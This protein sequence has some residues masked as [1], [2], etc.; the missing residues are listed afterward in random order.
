M[1]CHLRFRSSFILKPVWRS[2]TTNSFSQSSQKERTF[3]CSS[4]VSHLSILF[5]C[6]G[7]L[8]NFIGLERTHCHSLMAML[9]AWDR[10]ISSYLTVWSL[11][12]SASLFDLYLDIDS[13]VTLSRVMSPKKERR[14]AIWTLFVS[15]VLGALWPTTSSEYLS[16]SSLR[17][18]CLARS[19]S[20][21]LSS[22]IWVWIFA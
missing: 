10:T 20:N 19:L 13:G 7:I 17:V 11:T 21:H 4:W 12:P 6:C 22:V 3:S 1:S 2:K 18:C 14:C 5:S 9:K 15:W 16:M 8:M